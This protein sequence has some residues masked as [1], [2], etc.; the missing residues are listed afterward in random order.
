MASPAELLI[1]N[2]SDVSEPNSMNY[3]AIHNVIR[4]YKSKL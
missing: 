3:F 2:T 1:N 4:S